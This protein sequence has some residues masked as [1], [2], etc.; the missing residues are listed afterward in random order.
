MPKPKTAT[1]TLEILNDD[2]SRSI[3][4][5]SE[6][7]A[8]KIPDKSQ[9][10][11][12]RDPSHML[13]GMVDPWR[14]EDSDWYLRRDRW[15]DNM[16]RLQPRESHFFLNVQL[17]PV[18]PNGAFYTIQE[19]EA[20][21][22]RVVLCYTGGDPIVCTWSEKDVQKKAAEMLHFGVIYFFLDIP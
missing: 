6:L 22:T 13:V 18:N 14:D 12:E 11:S 19:I 5:S 17:E 1:V 8:S 20:P 15:V 10:A 4:K 7:D 2:G 21:A 16:V 3:V 9:Y